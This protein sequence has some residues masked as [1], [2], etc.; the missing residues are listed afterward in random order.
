MMLIV[1]NPRAMGHLTLSRR[2]A[3]LGWAATAVMAVATVLFF[4][5]LF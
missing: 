5:S 1:T 3:V 2:G 4:A